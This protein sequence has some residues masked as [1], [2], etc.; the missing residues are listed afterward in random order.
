MKNTLCI[1]F[2]FIFAIFSN[3]ILSNT[4]VAQSLTLTPEQKEQ[5]LKQA[6]A[7]LQSLTPEQKEAL[8]QQAPE[9]FKSWPSEKKEEI[10]R[11]A[12]EESKS[13]ALK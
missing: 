11:Q 12:I 10:L 13:L 1:F 5:F 8:F 3:G 2:F 6:A 9:A 4:A 7:T